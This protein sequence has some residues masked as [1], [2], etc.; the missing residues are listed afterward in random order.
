[1][2]DFAIFLLG[3]MVGMLIVMFILWIFRDNIRGWKYE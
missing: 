3:I 2:T 1:M